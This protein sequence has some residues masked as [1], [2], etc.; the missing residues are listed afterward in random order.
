MHKRHLLTDRSLK[1]DGKGLHKTE[2]CAFLGVG[3][4]SLLH[5]LVEMFYSPSMKVT[6][7]INLA[8]YLVQKAEDYIDGCGGPIDLGVMDW[9]DDSC[10]MLSQE[11]IAT[12]IKRMERREGSLTK[13]MLK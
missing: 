2:N 10:R 1:F 13:I 6:E 7:G 11:E 8:L 3:D 12:R 9:T 5:F 4:S